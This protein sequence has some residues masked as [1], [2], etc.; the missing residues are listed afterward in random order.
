MTNRP[1]ICRTW[2]LLLVLLGL[3][4]LVIGP[5]SAYMRAKPIEEKLGFVPSVNVIKALSAD[6]K[7]L[8][9]AGLV[10]KVMM[11]F[12]GLV[13]QDEKTVAQPPDYVG[14]SRMLHGAVK[15][16]PYN[17]DAYYFAQAFLVWDVGQVKVA[18]DLLDYGMRYRSWDWYLPYFAGFNHGYFLKDYDKAAS[19]Y[20]KAG[21]LTGEPLFI[22]LTGRYLQEAG[23]T[24]LA[25]GYLKGM[26]ATARDELARKSFATRLKA[27][28]EVRRIEIA[29]DRF[30][31]K[32]G[33][34]PESVDELLKGGDLAP[35]PA[36]PY[37]GKFFLD[38][39]GKVT[40]TS[41]FAFGAGSKKE[42]DEKH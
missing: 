3:Y 26:L 24:E 25:I 16:D 1:P 37:G 36:D 20:K 6:H 4:P 34:L 11:Y 17:S 30:R 38:E 40:T 22:S 12:G 23:Q 29:R 33:R 19:Y 14:M 32:T 18:N 28:E 8:L 7:E 31:E 27:F 35:P 5:F 10:L 9:G 13:D 42:T 41:K 2:L 15:L 21:E 39:A